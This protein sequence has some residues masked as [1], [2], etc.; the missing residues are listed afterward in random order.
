[1]GAL[2]AEERAAGGA[3]ELRYEHHSDSAAARDGQVSPLRRAAVA[4]LPPAQCTAAAD[5]AA[6]YGAGPS[7]ARARPTA[8][9]AS[10]AGEAAPRAAAAVQAPGAC[11]GGGGEHGGGQGHERRVLTTPVPL[12]T[13]AVGPGAPG[14]G[15][16]GGARG[17]ALPAAVYDTLQAR[18]A[19]WQAVAQGR[20]C[21]A[22][23]WVPASRLG[24]RM[25]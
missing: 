14:A 19:P 20:R 24:K 23:R 4:G 11:R 3:T 6:Q 12:C 8:R 1:M 5:R 15:D 25:T 7:E 9:D 17:G 18:A 22:P 10:A 2:A 16:G 13:P 21:S